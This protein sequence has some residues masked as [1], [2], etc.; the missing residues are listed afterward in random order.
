[1]ARFLKFLC[2]ILPL[3]GLFVAGYLSI[4]HAT[5]DE[6]ACGKSGGC[7]E[8]AMWVEKNL[9]NFPV[10]YVGV[11]GYFLLLALGVLWM[12]K[13]KPEVKPGLIIS[14]FGAVMSVALM[15]LSLFV[16]KAE[17]R[18]CIASAAIML[19]TFGTYYWMNRLTFEV[20]RA[21]KIEWG[22]LALGVVALIVATERYGLASLGTVVV[23]KGPI[24][25][26]IPA[27]PKEKGNKD[28]P[29]VVVEFFDF[30]C[31]HCRK[32]NE[33]LKD[34][35]D[36]SNNNFRLVMR[37]APLASPGHEKGPAAALIG[38]FAHEKG[39]FWEYYNLAFK[40]DAT[41]ATIETFIAVAAGLGLDKAEI[42]RRRK[43]PKDPVVQ[44]WA[45]DLNMMNNVGIGETPMFFVATP[46]ALE[47][48][49]YT[50][51]QFTDAMRTGKYSKY[52]N[53]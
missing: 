17:C 23:I 34:L 2:L 12:V 32:V 21:D 30:T 41:V 49:V 5:G 27:N 16:I 39:K 31:I 15:V 6:I 47:V 26:Y 25:L 4:K 48:D 10:A 50:Q 3:G 51:K 42:E 36:K 45:D 19:A 20:K 43:D 28:A 1:M 52:I 37:N 11:V 9:G 44:L 8:V 38:E 14:G 13:G 53:R 24:S 18:W 29:I 40:E 35:L 46:T 7:G 22:A 33:E